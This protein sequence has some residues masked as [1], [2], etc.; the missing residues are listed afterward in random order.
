MPHGAAAVIDWR[1]RDAEAVEKS[2]QQWRLNRICS[3]WELD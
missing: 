2:R 3:G 1:L